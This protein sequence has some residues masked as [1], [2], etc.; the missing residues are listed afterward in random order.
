MKT[1]EFLPKDLRA[2]LVANGAQGRELDH[3]PVVKIIDPLGPG[4]W[5]LTEMRP[6]GPD[7]VYGL[8]FDPSEERGPCLGYERLSVLAAKKGSVGGPLER[9]THFAPRYPLSVYRV[10]ARIIGRV[11]EDIETLY[12]V[13]TNLG[14]RPVAPLSNSA[15]QKRNRANPQAR[16][17]RPKP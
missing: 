10:A 13:A 15:A 14:I 8:I 9:D 4:T 1:T 12:L 16:N 17:P 11:T 6:D 3:V 7:V 2:R 5:L